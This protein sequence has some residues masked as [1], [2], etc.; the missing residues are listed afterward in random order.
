MSGLF[1]LKDYFTNKK[2]EEFLKAVSR[3]SFFMIQ[4]HVRVK[5]DEKS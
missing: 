3:N 1:Q 2:K 4:Y 5:D